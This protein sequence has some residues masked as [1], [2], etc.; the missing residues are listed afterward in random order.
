[1]SLDLTSLS[2]Q[3]RQM[4]ATL[5]SRT[6]TT[7]ERLA[8]LCQT[9]LRQAGQEAYWEQEINQQREANPWRLLARPFTETLTTIREAPPAPVA[10]QIIATDGSQIDVDRHGMASFFLINIG[11]VYLRYGEHPIAR[12]SSQPMLS[13]REE[14]LYIQDGPRKIAIE[15]NYLNALRD[16]HEMTVLTDLCQELCNDTTHMLALLDGTLMRWALAGFEK[17]VKNDFLQKYLD[18]LEYLR[19]Q[20]IPVASYIS[21]PRATEVINTIALMDGYSNG[22]GSGN[23]STSVHQT[24][25]SQPSDQS[26]E[27]SNDQPWVPTSI[28]GM[29]DGDIFFDMLAEGQRGPLFASMSRI[30]VESY[31]DHLVHFFYMRVGREMVRVEIPLWI[32]EDSD[33]VD[34]VHSLVYDQCMRGQGYPVALARAH[35]QAVVRSADRRAFWRMVEGSLV[36]AEVPTTSSSKQE[37]KEYSK[38]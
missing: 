25:A 6:Q 32:A 1:M 11:R 14:E 24:D 28:N 13:Y 36:R 31:G 19:E 16:I 34:L 21:R 5:A 9:Y 7:N 4:S 30:N 18:G 29:V 12:L 20:D 33:L 37:N 8:Y 23:V 22:N 38:I 35:E 10:Y 2:K 15:G 3:V 26:D 27:H 17:S